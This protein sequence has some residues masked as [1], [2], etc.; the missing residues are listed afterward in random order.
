ML[1]VDPALGDNVTVLSRRFTNIM[2]AVSRRTLG[3]SLRKLAFEGVP[4]DV[5]SQTNKLR[6]MHLASAS[7]DVTDLR[8]E[9][10]I[11]EQLWPVRKVFSD[12]SK[13]GST[14]ESGVNG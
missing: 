7:S 9:I 3:E 4:L 2:A 12:A 13:P 1:D 14:M 6:S 8:T 10:D 5:F 11:S